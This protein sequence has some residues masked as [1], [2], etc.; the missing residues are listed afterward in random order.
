MV[1]HGIIRY[2][3]TQYAHIPSIQRNSPEP[4]SCAETLEFG[5]GTCRESPSVALRNAIEID[6]GSLLVH[7]RSCLTASNGKE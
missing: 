4:C 5:F 3:T 1:L 7:V 6:P 2:Y